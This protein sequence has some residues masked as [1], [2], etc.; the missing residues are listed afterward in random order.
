MVLSYKKS[1]CQ[2]QR[3][4]K[5]KNHLIESLPGKENKTA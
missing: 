3:A 2:A 5:F 4:Q 1:T